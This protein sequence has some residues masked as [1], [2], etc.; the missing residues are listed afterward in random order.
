MNDKL[1]E[2]VY[3]LVAPI[4]ALLVFYGATSEEAVKLWAT[5]VGV[6]L[7]S[8]MNIVAAVMVHLQRE[9]GRLLRNADSADNSRHRRS[10]Q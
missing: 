4:G 8:G 6:T 5:L 9:K 1:R 7:T 10:D 3:A 2:S